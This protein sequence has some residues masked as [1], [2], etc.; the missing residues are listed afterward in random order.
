MLCCGSL[1]PFV[2]SRVVGFSLFFSLSFKVR[3]CF[4]FNGLDESEMSLKKTE[5]FF[6]SVPMGVS[7]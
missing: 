2:F 4:F 3:A 1:V 7:S 6:R 5:G